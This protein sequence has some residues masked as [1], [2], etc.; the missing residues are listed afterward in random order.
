AISRPN[1]LGY[2]PSVTVLDLPAHVT[3]TATFIGP[4]IMPGRMRHGVSPSL[5][6]PKFTGRFYWTQRSPAQSLQS[7]AKNTMLPPVAISSQPFRAT[8]PANY[9]RDK[10]GHGSPRRGS[11]SRQPSFAPG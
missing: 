9:L 11:A 8:G 4:S 1:K 7:W 2:S 3:W 6:G 10:L 5:T